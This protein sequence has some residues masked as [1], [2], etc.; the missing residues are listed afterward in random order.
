RKKRL[1]RK[2]QLQ[3]KSPQLKNLLQEQ[4]FQRKV[5]QKQ[6]L[7]NV[8]QQRRDQQLRRD[9]QQRRDQQLRKL[10]Q[11]EL[12]SYNLLTNFKRVN[13]NFQVDSF[14]YKINPFSKFP[15]RLNNYLHP[16]IIT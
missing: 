4:V 5:L 11:E 14:F 2:K 1:L 9:Q 6:L 10:P 15:L 13:L 12:S 16:S 7:R 3:R 8:L